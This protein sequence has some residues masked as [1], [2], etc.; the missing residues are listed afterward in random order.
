MSH[1]VCGKCHSSAVYADRDSFGNVSVVCL[2]CGNRAYPGGKGFY[3]VDEE[4]D[5]DRMTV[6]SEAIMEQE[7]TK[8]RRGYVRYAKPGQQFPISTLIVLPV[9]Q[10]W[11]PRSEKTKNRP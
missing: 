1:P 7:E 8:K 11:L 9:W 3:M 5:K 10:N 2:M 6:K 4:S